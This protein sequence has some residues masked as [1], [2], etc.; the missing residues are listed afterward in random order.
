MKLTVV[1]SVFDGERYLAK[2]LG[3]VLAQTH[4]EFDCIVVNNGSTDA[5]GRIL[6]AFAERD[7]RV[8]V[9]HNQTTLGYGGGR[10]L[11]IDRARTEWVALMDADDLCDPRRFERQVAFIEAHGERL[12]AVGTWARYIDENDVPIGHLRTPLTT[13]DEFHRRFRARDSLVLLDPSAVLHRPT[14]LAVGGYRP[15]TVPAADLD[16][17]YRIAESGRMI[18]AIPEVLMGYRIHPASESVARTMFQRKRAHFI[19]YNMRRRRDHQAEVGWDVFEREIWSDLRYRLPRL[20]RDWGFTF[21]KRAGL[22]YG[23]RRYGAL[24]GSLLLAALCNP[25]LVARRLAVQLRA[26]WFG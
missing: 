2:A 8:R 19:N 26:A 14:F 17:W 6:D 10:T 15:D 25:L 16:L 24:C 13:P 12:G 1:M 21:F 9:I 23:R 20:R 5:T 18:L 11:G 22:H 4:T 3:S 7:P